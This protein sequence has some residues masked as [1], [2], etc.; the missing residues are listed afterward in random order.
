MVNKRKIDQIENDATK[1]SEIQAAKK[2]N[3]V[4]KRKKQRETNQ[5]KKAEFDKSLYTVEESSGDN[6]MPWTGFTKSKSRKKRI[7]SSD[8]EDMNIE[9]ENHPNVSYH[10]NDFEKAEAPRITKVVHK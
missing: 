8:E 10:Q 3:D 6:D 4:P 2:A 9:N 1:K 7:A 5:S